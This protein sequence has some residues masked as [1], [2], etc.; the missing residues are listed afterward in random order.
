MNQALEMV[1][2]I[3]GR[4]EHLERFIHQLG[5]HHHIR[6]HDYSLTIRFGARL[7]G[8]ATLNRVLVVSD[9]S[10]G[11]EVDRLA[12]IEEFVKT[13][14]FSTPAPSIPI[15]ALFFQDCDEDLATL[16]ARLG[17]HKHLIPPLSYWHRV[18]G[19]LKLPIQ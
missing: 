19:Q 3:D 4:L 6:G 15:D 1:A 16:L 7:C 14:L 12:T 5:A 18:T 9:V 13:I 17:F 8:A 10:F 11:E 2:H